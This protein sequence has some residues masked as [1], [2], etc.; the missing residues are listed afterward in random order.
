MKSL[1]AAIFLAL[2]APSLAGAAPSTWLVDKATSSLA[3]SS[4]MGGEAFSG[5]FRRWDADIRFD[6][7]DLAHSSVAVT[8]DVASATTSNADRDQALPTAAFFDAPVFPRATYV[9]RSFTATGPNRYRAAGVLTL[10]GVAKPL[11]LPFTLVIT[12]PAA[13]MSGRVAIN[14]LAFG[15]GQNEWKATTTLPAAVQL[16]ISLNA[17]RAK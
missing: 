2:A 15:V 8:I 1:L 5:M 4:S 13:R 17:R 3:F 7:A 9:A 16:T 12:G 11:T 6:P 14:R 10:R